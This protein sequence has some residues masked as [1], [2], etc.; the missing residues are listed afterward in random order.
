MD[1][2]DF[3]DYIPTKKEKKIDREKFLTQFVQCPECGY[4]NK[5]VFL[6]RIGSCKCCGKILEPKAHMKYVIN[7][8][9][10]YYD[11]K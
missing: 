9:K 7:K 10:K 1:K 2:R 6:E 11:K 3:K 5:K 4:R 8:K